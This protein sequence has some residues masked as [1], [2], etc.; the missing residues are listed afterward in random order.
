M[1]SRAQIVATIGPATNDIKKIRQLANYNM[2]V[3]RLNFAWGEYEEH[4]TYI[5][6]IRQVAEENNKRIPI[7]QDLAGPRKQESSGHHFD[8][9][10]EIITAKDLNDLT[11][12]LKQGV[13]YVAMSYIASSQDIKQLKKEMSDRNG[14]TPIIA[15]IER[16][17]A[18]DDI[19]NIVQEAD[20]IMIARGDLGINISLEKVPFAQHNIIQKA[21]NA[22]K[23]TIVATE[24]L[25]SMTKSSQPTRAEVSDVAHAILDGTSAVMLSEETA[26]GKYPVAAV[27]MMEKIIVE[28]EKHV[29]QNQPRYS[30]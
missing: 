25:L 13:D 12:G 16:P 11:F 21:K 20:A 5:Q 17:E 23:P 10:Q 29:P 27:K 3:A 28:S 18:L 15:K 9:S 1:A 2:D 19:G 22:K 8:E 6:I 30:L 7:I 26:T 4:A 14:D 24:M